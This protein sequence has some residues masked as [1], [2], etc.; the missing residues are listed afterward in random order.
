MGNELAV[1]TRLAEFEQRSLQQHEQFIIWQPLEGESL[2]EVITGVEA[3]DHPR[4][5]QQFQLC[6]KDKTG[7]SFRIWL[8]KYLQQG[9][10]MKNAQPNDLVGISYHGKRKGS[11]GSEY[12]AYQLTIE[13]A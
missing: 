13:K 10:L 3:V 11:N 8:S 6:L 12:H 9:L 4:F 1:A 2:F 7:Q 5:G